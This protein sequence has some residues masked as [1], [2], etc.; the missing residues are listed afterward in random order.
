GG[1]GGVGGGWGG[2]VGGYACV[3]ADHRSGG[4]CARGGGVV[5]VR[6]VV[7]ALAVGRD[8]HGWTWAS[9]ALLD[10]LM[11]WRWPRIMAA[12]FAGVML[13]VA[14][15]IIQ[16]LTRN[17]M[18]SPEGLGISPGAA[19]A[20]G[21]MRFLVPGNAFGWRVSPGVPWWRGPFFS[22]VTPPGR[23]GFPPPPFFL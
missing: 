23:G 6:G 19:F 10:D 3:G 2:G 4:A 21:L 8:A 18:A 9:G 1:G 22:F 16:R 5:L 11:P 17:P 15:C 7:V 13:A 20:G 12:L 14:G